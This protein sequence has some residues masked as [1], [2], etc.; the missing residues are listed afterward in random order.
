MCCFVTT[1]STTTKKYEDDI[2]KQNEIMK[3]LN[4]LNF[5][6][7]TDKCFVC[8]CDLIN[9]AIDCDNKKTEEHIIPKWVQRKYNL[10]TKLMQLS[11]GTKIQYQHLKVQCCHRCNENMKEFFEDTIYNSSLDG[12]ECV[13]KLDDNILFLWATKISYSLAYK[14]LFLPKDRAKPK[15]A[16]ICSAY[17]MDERIMERVFLEAVVLEK[18]IAPKLGSVFTFELID[19]KE[20]DFFVSD[21]HN[22]RF[23]YIQLG[24]TGIAVCTFDAGLVKKSIFKSHC[25]IRH[26]TK[27]EFYLF[28]MMCSNIVETVFSPYYNPLYFIDIKDGFWEKD[29]NFFVGKI[30]F[31]NEEEI[32]DRLDCLLV[33]ASNICCCALYKK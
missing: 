20:N 29:K 26:I 3:R 15:E 24:K 13:K 31:G 28:C 1:D 16:M 14:E 18:D 5:S 17:D 32:V 11:N 10:W 12:F 7:D 2:L 25:L 22:K 30:G 4:V 33:E 21:L 19:A 8:G 27:N 9:S 23:F 6:Y